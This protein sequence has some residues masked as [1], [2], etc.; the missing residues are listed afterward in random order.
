LLSRAAPRSASLRY[1][2]SEQG[3]A[4]MGKAGAKPPPPKEPADDDE[5]AWGEALAAS[6]GFDTRSSLPAERDKPKPKPA[7]KRKTPVKSD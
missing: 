5:S 2:E 3:D 7:R 1:R 6:F 4:T